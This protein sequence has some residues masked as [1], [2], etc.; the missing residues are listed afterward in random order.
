MNQFFK[1]IMTTK[2]GQSFD[3][4]RVAM[5]FIIIAL[6]V[7]MGSGMT[8]YAFGYLTNKPFNIKEYFDAL[9]SFASGVS[10]LL[11]SGSLGLKLKAD[12][13]PNKE[14]SDVAPK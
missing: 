10:A 8:L 4:V 11:V 7:A 6:I 5:V 13:E 2:D 3:V 12:T 14:A 9:L 1:D